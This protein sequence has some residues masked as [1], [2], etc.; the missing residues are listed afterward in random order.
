MKRSE[1]QQLNLAQRLALAPYSFWALLFIVVPLF[2]VAYYAF[3]D[4]AF[5]FTT[6]N[7][8]RFFTATS[9]VTED[10]GSIREVHTY[11]LIFWRSLKLA[12]ISTVICLIM[13][14]PIAYILSRASARTQKILITLIMIPMWMNFL[15]RTYAWMTILQDTGILNGIL[16]SLSLQ[17]IHIIGTESAVVIGMVYDYFPYMILPIYSV[18]AKMDLKL[19]EAARDLGC[20]SFGVLRRV[21]FPLSLPGVISGI[22]MVLIPSIS[23]FYISQKLG[24]GKFYLI[25][26]AIEGQYVAN[27]LHFAAAIAFILMVVLLIS[28]AFMQ[29]YANSK[30]AV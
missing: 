4:S 24:N 16:R 17:P 12:V 21:I 15:I 11:L 9:S 18:M 20:N 7:I 1:K 5:H 8:T 19:L 3:T 27:N 28:M 25:G 30:A 22:T 26:D 2:F 14:Y 23:T 6:E 13:G 29:R 10:N